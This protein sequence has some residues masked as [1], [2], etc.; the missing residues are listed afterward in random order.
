MTERNRTVDRI[1]A[2]V[3]VSDTEEPWPFYAACTNQPETMDNTR[4]PLVWDALTI[5]ASCPVVEQC[6]RWAETE[7]EYV[8]VAGGAVWTSRHRGRRSTRTIDTAAS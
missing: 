6:R 3:V 8:G 5:C 4:P 2:A 1:A 7:T